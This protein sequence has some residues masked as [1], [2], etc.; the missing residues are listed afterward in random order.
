VALLKLDL[1]NHAMIPTSEHGRL[2]LPGAEGCVGYG[3]GMSPSSP[4]APRAHK[5]RR[6]RPPAAGA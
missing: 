2:W 1:A 3:H 6:A 4:R 5:Q